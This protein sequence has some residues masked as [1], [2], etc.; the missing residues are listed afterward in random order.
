MSLNFLTAAVLLC[1]AA[2][3]SVAAL[4]SSLKSVCLFC[5]CCPLVV[6]YTVSTHDTVALDSL[7]AIALVPVS[8][9]GYRVLETL[10][11]CHSGLFFDS[12]GLNMSG[13]S[14]FCV[15]KQM[16]HKSGNLVMTCIYGITQYHAYNYL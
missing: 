6:A 9:R 8:H 16:Q 1:S 4:C 3:Q 13:A 12:H 2:Y 11:E 10:Q 15:A 14:K 7:M 5:L